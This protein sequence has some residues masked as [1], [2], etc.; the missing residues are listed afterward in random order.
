MEL[1]IWT[2]LEKKN[3]GISQITWKDPNLET[4][5]TQLKIPS[6]G[7]FKVL[8]KHFV[9]MGRE[10]LK[11]TKSP[12]TQQQLAGPK[13][14]A[15]QVPRTPWASYKPCDWLG[16]GSSESSTKVLG[17]LCWAS[18]TAVTIGLGFLTRLSLKL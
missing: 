11:E 2:P 4:E 18:G 16:L 17:H 12:G 7:I 6:F 15:A 1:R 5:H 14:P 13:Q 8:Y 9:L 10:K 3:T